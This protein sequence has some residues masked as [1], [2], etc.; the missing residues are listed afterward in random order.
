MFR[1]K[2]RLINQ[3]HNTRFSMRSTNYPLKFVCPRRSPVS[4]YHCQIASHGRGCFH[5]RG[6]SCFFVLCF[7]SDTNCVTG[8]S[9]QFDVFLN[10]AE[11]LGKRLFLKLFRSVTIVVC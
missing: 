1:D 11:R 7:E 5:A 8:E 4:Q 10:A 3:R 6:I 2:R 9:C